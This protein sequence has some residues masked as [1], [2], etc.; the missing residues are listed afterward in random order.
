MAT[1]PLRGKHVVI[2]GASSGIG[3]GVALEAAKRGARVS[4]AARSADA[5]GDIVREIVAAGGA[6][7]AYPTDVSDE[8]ACRRLVDRAI[9]AQG[10]IDV[11]IC[12]AGLGSATQGNELIDLDV[13]RRLM[14]VNFLGAVYVTAAALESL[15]TRRGLVV[16]VSSLQGLLSLPKSSAYSASKHAM[17]GYFSSLRIDLRDSGVGVLIVSP[18]AV[19]TE[20]HRGQ[21]SRYA[22]MTMDKVMKRS[23]PVATCATLICDAIEERRRDLVMTFGGKLMLR[24]RPFLPSFVDGM[25][26]R[27]VHRLYE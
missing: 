23:M 6:A 15:R 2:T 1:Y 16:A 22:S 4:L 17:Q 8:T 25:V 24:L 3:R 10:E 5:L 9:A 20:I 27:S 18:G 19:A 7:A 12:N 13:I 14:D 21:E 26:T 11:L